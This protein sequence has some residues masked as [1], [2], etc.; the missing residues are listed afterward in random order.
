LAEVGVNHAVYVTIL[1]FYMTLAVRNTPPPP[2]S[3]HQS[4]LLL[5]ATL[6]NCYVLFI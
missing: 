5:H 4:D 6:K 1:I 2:L 3:N